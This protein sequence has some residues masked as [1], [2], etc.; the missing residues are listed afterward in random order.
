VEQLIHRIQM[1]IKDI[2]LITINIM[3]NKKPL[4]KM[5]GLFMFYFMAVSP[6]TYNKQNKRYTN[7]KIII[8]NSSGYSISQLK[9][10]G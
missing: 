7:N 4:G 9:S 1:I 6:R 8:H 2:N 3:S 10:L 5:R